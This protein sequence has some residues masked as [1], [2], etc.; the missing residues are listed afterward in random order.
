MHPL[1]I[2]THFQ[3]SAWSNVMQTCLKRALHIAVASGGLFFLGAGIAA[4]D[5][6]D[7]ADVVSSVAGA[8]SPDQTEAGDTL[9][10]LPVTVSDATVDVLSDNGAPSEPDAAPAD[11]SDAVIDVPISVTDIDVSVVDGGDIDRQDSTENA[12]A[13]AAVAIPSDDAGSLVDAPITVSDVDVAVLDRDGSAVADTETA[14][15]TAGSDAVVDVPITVTEVDVSIV[16]GGHDDGPNSTDNTGTDTT[17]VSDPGVDRGLVK[18]PITITEVDVV[19]ADG[20]RDADPRGRP[21]DTGAC[22]YGHH[23]F[24]RHHRRSDRRLRCRDRRPG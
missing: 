2:Q 7:I 23:P 13:E 17:V 1:R 10:S 3:S 15:N 11:R 8:A 21:T 6:P 20:S 18:A 19:V 22:R 9:L 16:G 4:G 14:R 12:T 5:T 24:G